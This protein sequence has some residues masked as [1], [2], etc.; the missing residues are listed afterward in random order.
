[1]DPGCSFSD[2]CLARFR[3]L[4][5][6]APYMAALYTLDLQRKR[7]CDLAALFSETPSWSERLDLELAMARAL[8]VDGVELVDLRRLPLVSRYRVVIQ[9]ELVYVGHP[10]FLARFVDRTTRRYSDFY[11]ILEA[12]YWQAETAPYAAGL[13]SA[14]PWSPVTQPGRSGQ[15]FDRQ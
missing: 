9:G 15:P 6:R 13:P 3:E 12:L 14:A 4:C 8:D 2:S 7:S 5:S 1:M 10:E 11:P